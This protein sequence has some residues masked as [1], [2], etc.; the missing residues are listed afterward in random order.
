MGLLSTGKPLHW[1]A[2]NAASARARVKHDGVLQFIHAYRRMAETRRGDALKWGDEVEYTIVR[3]DDE[4]KTMFLSL[5]APEIIEVLVQEE[6]QKSAVETLWRPEYANWMVE[7]TPGVPYRCFAGDLDLVER[8]MNLRRSQIEKLLRDDEMV[9]SIT[10]FPR[11]GCDGFLGVAA[12]SEILGKYSRSLYIPDRAIN[13]HPRFSTLTR[14]IR[15]RR[16]SKVDIHVPVFADVQTA[17][18]FAVWP[19]SRTRCDNSICASNEAGREDDAYEKPSEANLRRT[20]DVYMDCMAFGMGM[21]CLQVTLQARDVCEARCLYD[22]LGVLAP[23]FLALTAATPIVKGFLVDTDVRWD[24][25]SASVDDRTLNERRGGEI[26]K[27]RYSSIDCFISGREKDEVEI[28]NDLPV[29]VNGDALRLLLDS[30]ID[31]RMAQHIAHLFIRDPIAVYE[32]MLEQDNETSTDHFENIQSTN[33]NTVRFKLPPPNSDIGW[34]TEFRSMEV[35][36]TDFENAAFSIFIVLVSRVILAFDLTLYMPMSLVDENMKSAHERNA[37]TEARF[38][39][40]KNIFRK[41]GQRPQSF[42]CSAGHVHHPKFGFELDV[43]IDEDPSEHDLFTIDEIING[44]PLGGDEEHRGFAFPGL[45]PLVEG[46]L[47]SIELSTSFRIRMQ[48]YIALISGRASGKLWTAAKFIRNFVANHPE[49]RM[50]SVVSDSIQYDL[51]H[52]CHRLGKNQLD[53]QGAVNLFGE[54]LSLHLSSDTL[55]GSP[56]QGM[57][58][59]GC[60]ESLRR[61]AETESNI[62]PGQSFAESLADRTLQRIT[63]R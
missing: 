46:Y 3:Y 37:V 2:S 22:Q 25:I 28:Y 53:T 58:E 44:K 21:S 30:G 10:G 56:C 39:F 50:D 26:L 1:H 41:A 5:R 29:A 6:K 18:D 40:R 27:S 33:W 11:L 59:V 23:I 60:L 45:L 48:R 9:L 36:L 14:N 61:K 13:P 38:F 31:E 49:Y 35:Q 19:E 42:V 4:T 43:E 54:E 51:L 52:S 32:E 24:V 15:L 17:E 47:E 62:L 34:R 12:D 55:C 57:D 20:A 63:Q 8:N 7:G 16:G